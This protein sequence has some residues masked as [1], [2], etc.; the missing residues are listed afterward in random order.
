V[1]KLYTTAFQTKLADELGRLPFE[2]EAIPL[3]LG[4]YGVLRKELRARP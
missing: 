1:P 2:Y 3:A 4:D